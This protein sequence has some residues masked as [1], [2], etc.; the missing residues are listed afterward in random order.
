MKTYE[1]N[2]VIIRIHGEESPARRRT[3]EHAVC[4]L[5]KEV[6]KNDKTVRASGESA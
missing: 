2:G 5:M 6:R 3:L 1:H 4:S